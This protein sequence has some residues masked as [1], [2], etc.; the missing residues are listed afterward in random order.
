MFHGTA[1][2]LLPE[3]RLKASGLVGSQFLAFEDQLQK[4]LREKGLSSSPET[5]H[6]V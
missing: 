4:L 6:L 1:S 5:I 2:E 3:S